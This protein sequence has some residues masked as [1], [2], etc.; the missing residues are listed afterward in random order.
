MN[1]PLKEAGIRRIAV[2]IYITP[3]LFLGVV[4]VLVA[5]CYGDLVRSFP[6]ILQVVVG[7]IAIAG[8]SYSLAPAVARW[9]AR[10]LIVGCLFGVFLCTVGVLAF[11]LTAVLVCA[12]FSLRNH[13]LAPL[14]WIGFFG[15]PVAAL[16]GLLFSGA[17][18]QFAREAE[19]AH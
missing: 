2:K 4:F 18:Q 11:G 5:I 1:Q 10:R 9:A 3:P 12:D 17:A 8:T 13:V 16:T 6:F 19:S 15:F 7:L 14:F